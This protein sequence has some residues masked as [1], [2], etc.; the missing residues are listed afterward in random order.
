MSD[1]G[2]I[3]T[4]IA[5]QFAR[6]RSADL[7][8]FTSIEPDAAEVLARCRAS[9]IQ[10]GG[11]TT[12]D[13][14]S[15]AALSKYAGDLLNLESVQSL[16]P[17]AAA[18]LSRF[19][20]KIFLFGL[21]N[22]GDEAAEQLRGKIGGD[23]GFVNR[24]TDPFPPC[25]DGA[26]IS[27]FSCPAIHLPGD[28]IDRVNAIIKTK[29]SQARLDKP[30]Q[31]AIKVCVDSAEVGAMHN[32]AELLKPFSDSDS[33]VLSVLTKATCS[34]LLKS[35]HPDIWKVLSLVCS[36]GPAAEGR[37][38]R[39]VADLSDAT[40]NKSTRLAELRDLLGDFCD[41]TAVDYPLLVRAV[42]VFVFRAT[43]SRGGGNL[44]LCFAGPRGSLPATHQCA[45]LSEDMADA[46]AQC[47]LNLRVDG[48]TESVA[49]T[50]GQSEK[51]RWLELTGVSDLSQAAARSLAAFPGYLKITSDTLPGDVLAVI[52]A[53]REQA[54][55]GFCK[56]VATS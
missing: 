39:A 31:Q 9:Q 10:L 1:A 36:V 37:F 46:L 27:L 18:S 49:N 20:G 14:A 47:S 3:T 28:A 38:M 21:T 15:A 56:P 6:T 53:G 35:F 34:K 32:A 22:I 25:S 45:A 7:R 52:M 19:T 16:T 13:D 29:A 41:L 50:L 26:L 40:T 8:S 43:R 33:A 4:A 51:V 5:E 2:L 55:D 11:L 17:A 54:G 12:I 42:K 48:I 44:S 30:R 24:P 23:I